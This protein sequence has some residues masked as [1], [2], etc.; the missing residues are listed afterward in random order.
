MIIYH[1]AINKDIQ[2]VTD[3]KINCLVT[4]ASY[5]KHI[6]QPWW[7]NLFIDSGAFSVHNSGKT[8]DIE[9]Y[10]EYLLEWESMNKKIVYASLDVI[11]DAKAGM[12]NYKYLLKKKLNPIPTYHYGESIDVLKE[13]IDMT[14]YIGLGGTVGGLGTEGKRLFFNK[15][16]SLYPNT[17]KFHAFGVTNKRL[18]INYPWHSIDSTTALR[19]STYGRINTPFG[20]FYSMAKDSKNQR[21]SADSKIERK[22][23][24]ET[25]RIIKEYFSKLGIKYEDLLGG[26]KKNIMTRAFADIKYMDELGKQAPKSF[27]KKYSSLLDNI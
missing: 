14:N 2:L 13:L 22:L 5:K 15:I 7:K 23:G 27:I 18:I 21:G 11:G 9:K 10:A 25:G 26:D 19:W 3:E 24:D 20:I 16:F 17:I 1:G 8:I 6:W 4:Y 12:K